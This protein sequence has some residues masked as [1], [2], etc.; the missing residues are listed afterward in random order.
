MSQPYLFHLRKQ[1]RPSAEISWV[2]LFFFLK[3]RKK[4]SL[5]RK[6]QLLSAEFKVFEHQASAPVSCSHVLPAAGD[7]LVLRLA[8]LCLSFPGGA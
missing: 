5:Q 6:I 2:G 3:K 8:A 4:I 1:H 7:T